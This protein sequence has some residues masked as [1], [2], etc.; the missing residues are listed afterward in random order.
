MTNDIDDTLRE[1]YL[2]GQALQ[3]LEL[4]RSLAAEADQWVE[5][6]TMHLTQ[7]IDE[8]R[9]SELMD[10]LSLR[11][12][13]KEA[14]DGYQGLTYIGG[15]SGLYGVTALCVYIENSNPDLFSTEKG[16]RARVIAEAVP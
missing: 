12:P 14:L 15:F 13:L 7:L 5:L 1:L 4:A 8:A 2:N 9:M 10:V 3:A 6:I 16:V 11:Q